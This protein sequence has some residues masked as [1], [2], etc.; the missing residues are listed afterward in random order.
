M[1]AAAAT[2][3]VCGLLGRRPALSTPA[4]R[5]Y[6][7]RPVPNRPRRPYF[8]DPE[9]PLAP[10]W[11]LTPKYAAKQYGRFG[12]ASGVDPAGL[13]PTPQRL[14]EV[15]DEER[16]WHP[17]LQTMQDSLREKERLQEEK[18]LA[19]E[20]LIKANMAKMP[21]MIADWRREKQERWEKA[22]ADK[23]RRGR[24]LAEA[25]EQLGYNVDPRSTKFQELVRD[26]EKKQRKQLKEQ[27]QQQ[28][29]EAR[30]V[31]LQAAAAASPE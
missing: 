25:R 27:K 2:R 20:N 6:K 5:Y 19:R 7:V 29:L 16:Q 10:R 30:A 23:L 11:Q 18:R 4:S 9:D 22:Q 31:A 24:L 26:L 8:P 1:A 15:E 14:R 28:K 17:D 3:Q 13:W 21:Q 12:A